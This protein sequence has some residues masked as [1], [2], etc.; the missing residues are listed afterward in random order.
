MNWLGVWAR[1]CVQSWGG[2]PVSPEEAAAVSASMPVNQEAAKVYAEGLEK[3]R[4]FD[5]AA[6]RTLL[7]KAVEVEPDYALAH[8]ALAEA[9]NFLGY[10]QKAQE[11]A[12]KAFDLSDKLSPQDNSLYKHA[13]SR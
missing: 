10:D 2:D 4:V 7:E 6:A 13:I 1:R 12:K 11:Q 8:S 9:W 3:L 5:A